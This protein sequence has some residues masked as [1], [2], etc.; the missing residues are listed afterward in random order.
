M[1]EDEEMSTDDCLEK[2]C[3]KQEQRNTEEAGKR[4]R[5]KEILFINS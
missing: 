2:Y 3:C 1:K 5:I 4:Y